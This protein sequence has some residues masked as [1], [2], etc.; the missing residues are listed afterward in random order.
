MMITTD[1]EYGAALEEINRLLGAPA[2]T[3]AGD[4]L[5]I[6][7]TLVKQYEARRWPPGSV[8]DRCLGNYRSSFT[9]G[10]PIALPPHTGGGNRDLQR[11]SYVPRKESG[12]A[13]E[14]T[15][16]TACHKKEEEYTRSQAQMEELA[17]LALEMKRTVEAL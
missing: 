8:C 13:W 9:P 17:R 11:Y 1:E 10:L 15:L 6:L 5:D 12:D 14:T 2:G 3:E 7:L 4:R 16:C